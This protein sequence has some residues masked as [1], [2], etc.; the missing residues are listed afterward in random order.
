MACQA[1]AGIRVVVIFRDVH[2]M[3]A[4]PTHIAPD[5]VF[6]KTESVD[7]Q[8]AEIAVCTEVVNDDKTMK[9]ILLSA[10]L[11][12]EAG[13]NGG[14]RK[15]ADHDPGTCHRYLQ[16]TAFCEKSEALGCGTSESVPL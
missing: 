13:K 16:I 9:S 8:I 1:D 6:V 14:R 11:T 2:L 5:G 15:Y 10:K 7:E 4:E 12:D 3:I